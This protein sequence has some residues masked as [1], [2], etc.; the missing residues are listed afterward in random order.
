MLHV[1]SEARVELHTRLLS[2]LAQEGQSSPDLGFRLATRED[3]LG[4]ALDLPR[5]RDQVVEHEG[6]SV[7]IMEPAVAER[8]AEQTLNAVETTDGTRLQIEQRRPS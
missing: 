4:L 3:R 5:E 1:T 6:R 8:L 2:A 7:L